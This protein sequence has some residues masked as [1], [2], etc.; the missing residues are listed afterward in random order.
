[1]NDSSTAQALITAASELFPAHGYDGTSIRAITSRANANLGAVTYHFGSKEALYAAVF[2]HVAEPFREH[3]TA[4]AMGGGSAL[5]RIAAVVAA[6]Y[7]YLHAHPEL[8]R[9][10]IHH[11]AGS[12]PLPEPARRILEGNHRV[13]TELIV[14]GQGE[15]TVRPDDP[16]LMALNIVSQPIWISL[17]RH[18]LQQ[19]IGI[20]QSDPATREH[21]LHTTL[22][23]VRAGL[24]AT[25]KEVP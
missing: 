14:A 22:Q 19:A 11:L 1:M 20:D 4:I 16:R 3:L 9:L 24:T 10:L 5:D 15:G 2:Q 6:V 8:P 7:E 18:F 17:V 25:P 21:V 13:M 12:R 23:F